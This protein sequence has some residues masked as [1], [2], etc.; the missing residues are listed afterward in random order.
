MESHGFFLLGF[1]LFQFLFVIRSLCHMDVHMATWI[2]VGQAHICHEKKAVIG[3][4]QSMTQPF[5]LAP[6]G[7]VLESGSYGVRSTDIVECERPILCSVHLANKLVSTALFFFLQS[8]DGLSPSPFP[9]RAFAILVILWPQG[10]YGPYLETFFPIV[11]SHITLEQSC[12]FTYL[13]I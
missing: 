12:T 9:S 2:L 11:F 13:Y 6:R 3:L 4:T 8:I 1:F 5:R 7:G 10:L